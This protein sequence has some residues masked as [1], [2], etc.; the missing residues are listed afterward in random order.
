[1][2]GDHFTTVENGHFKISTE[3][4][5][6][7]K[8]IPNSYTIDI[9]TP[10]A[11]VQP[12]NVQSVIGTSGEYL[13]GPYVVTLEA[14]GK[15]V[16]A[17]FP[18]N[19]APSDDEKLLGF[20]IHYTQKISVMSDGKVIPIPFDR[21]SSSIDDINEAFMVCVFSKAE[22]GPYSSFDDGKSAI[23]IL[24]ECHDQWNAYVDACIKSGDTDGSCTAKSAI[25]AQG[26][27]KLLNK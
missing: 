16:P 21:A 14:G 18:R 4:T 19:S 11:S 3:L 12:H 9:V 23:R 1:L 24:G 20:M 5:G 26:A 17:K 27:L 15:Y 2:I 22:N 13:R 7:Q 10:M 25:L 8:L 6:A